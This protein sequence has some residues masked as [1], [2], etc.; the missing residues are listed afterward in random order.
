MRV[1]AVLVTSLAAVLL[2]GGAPLAPASAQDTKGTE[3]QACP[4]VKVRVARATTVDG[5]KVAKGVYRVAVRGVTCDRAETLLEEWVATGDVDSG[6]AAEEPEL[7]ELV[8]VDDQGTDA[9]GDDDE[10][11][12]LKSTAVAGC[13]I[14]VACPFGS[15]V[16]VVNLS[17]SATGVYGP[18]IV[19]SNAEGVGPT[20]LTLDYGG[21]VTWSR[22]VSGG[23]RKDL[24][25]S[26]TAPTGNVT[27]RLRASSDDLGPEFC[28]LGPDRY[29]KQAD[30]GELFYC[31]RLR[32]VNT[33]RTVE[34]VPLCSSCGVVKVRVDRAADDTSQGSPNTRLRKGRY[35][36]RVT[37]YVG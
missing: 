21:S 8:L 16:T 33:G 19:A 1:R 17:G 11:R 15:T 28:V 24:E 27:L 13:G 3:V 22:Y 35:Q 18:P 26:V 14:F 36:Y 30:P 23:G 7:G 31:F 4:E 6:F 10:I 5:E 34:G 20:P 12:M 32:D 29:R 37:V 25:V 2:V 9:A